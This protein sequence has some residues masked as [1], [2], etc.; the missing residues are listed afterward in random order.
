MIKMKR[1][2]IMI[3]YESLVNKY[4]Y[5]SNDLDNIIK[6]LKDTDYYENCSRENVSLLVE[7]V[8]VFLDDIKVQK[9]NVILERHET[10]EEA[11]AYFGEEFINKFD[12]LL[13]ELDKQQ[14]ILALHGTA[15]DDCP[16]ICEEGLK[17]TYPALNSTAISQSMAYGEGEM[18]YNKYEELLNWKHKNY[19]GLVM[20]AVPYECY[21][22]EGIWNHYQ[23]TDS[24]MIYSQDYKINPDFIVGYIDVNDKKIVVNP[25]YNRNH[26][27]TGLVEDMDIYRENKELDNDKIANIM[28]K[29]HEEL[30]SSVPTNVEEKKKQEEEIDIQKVPEYIENLNYTFN[31]IKIGYPDAMNEEKYKEILSDLSNNFTKVTKALPFLKTN[32]ELKKSAEPISSPVSVAQSTDEFTFDD[33]FFDDDIEWEDESSM[34][35]ENKK[36]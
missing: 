31:S 7:S 23:E 1:G 13:T 28:R 21:Y 18:H 19:K 4:Y 34:Q 9:E 17:Y 14:T 8:N 26:D 11:R 36:L 16:K 12:K 27:Y 20:I 30:Q 22:K 24:G 15:P 2:K 5:N 3:K 35:Q 6:Q 33:A 32:E 25:K 10:E 29:N